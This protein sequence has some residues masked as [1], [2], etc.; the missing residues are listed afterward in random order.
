LFKGMPVVTITAVAV[1]GVMS[2][3]VTDIV[4]LEAK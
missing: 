1:N 2:L 4:P 3:E